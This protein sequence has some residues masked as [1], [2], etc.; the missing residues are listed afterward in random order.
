MD[1][2]RITITNN[3]N[4]KDLGC[5]ERLR[6]TVEAVNLHIDKE[7]D[8]NFIYRSKAKAIKALTETRKKLIENKEWNSDASKCH[9]LQGLGITYYNAYA[10]MG[11]VLC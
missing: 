8:Y 4:E 11:E 2:T 6:L 3:P 1:K 9:H 7:D 10:R 5:I